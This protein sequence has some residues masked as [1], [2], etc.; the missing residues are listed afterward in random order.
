MTTATT[1]PRIVFAAAPIAPTAPRALCCRSC[2]AGLSHTFVDLGTSPLCQRHV[3]AQTF[4]RAENFYPLHVYVCDRCWLVQLPEYVAADEIFDDEYAYFSSYAMLEHGK[5]YVEQIIPR[6]GLKRGSRVVEVA[7]NDGYLLQHFLPHNIEVLGIEPTA[8]T[9]EAARKKGV[10]TLVRFFGKETARRVVAEFGPADL[11]VANNVLAHVPDINDFVAGF[12]VLLNPKGGV[13]TFEFPPLLPLIANNYF[14]TIYHEHFSY[15]SLTAVEPLFARHG[16]V[17]FDVE[18]IGTHGGSLRVYVRHADDA[19]RPVTELVG[20]WRDR[21][22]ASGHT[23]LAYYQGFGERV[24]ETK[25]KILD[26]LIAANRAGKR[27]AAYGAPGKGNTLLN[28]CGIRTDFIEYT[29]D[30]SPHKQGGFLPGTR[31]PIH[32]PDKVRETRPDYLFLL[33]WNFKD[34]V[35]RQMAHVREWGCQFVVPLPEP[36]VL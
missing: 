21:E 19:S 15:L 36:V 8:N 32:H 25:R 33:A 11:T 24:K 16:L 2:G 6:V 17:V 12:K 9:A 28:Y 29:V 7:S 3:T 35:M 30:R 26:F 13:G 34:D 4:D 20:H 5:R 1:D 31:I 22:I 23:T 18:E 14:D 27:V 10:Q